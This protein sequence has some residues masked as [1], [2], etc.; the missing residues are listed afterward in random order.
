MRAEFVAALGD[1]ILDQRGA[2]FAQKFLHFI[3][4]DLVF[5]PLDPLP[6][7]EPTMGAWNLTALSGRV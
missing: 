7:L 6:S 1:E 3:R 5:A 2:A 4:S